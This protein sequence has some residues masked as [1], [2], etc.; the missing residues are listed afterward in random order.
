MVKVIRSIDYQIGLR[1]FKIIALDGQNLMDDQVKTLLVTSPPKKRGAP[2]DQ[3]PRL[4]TSTF[5]PTFPTPAMEGDGAMPQSEGA[6]CVIHH[7][8][9]NKNTTWV[10]QPILCCVLEFGRTLGGSHDNT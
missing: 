10:G 9:T 1:C 4:A 7:V 8:A 2:K 3:P 5:C 6:G